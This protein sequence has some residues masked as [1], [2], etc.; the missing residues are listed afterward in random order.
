MIEL[1]NQTVEIL[2]YLIVETFKTIN[3]I[4]YLKPLVSVSSSDVCITQYEK[5]NRLYQYM[6]KTNQLTDE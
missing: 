2:N 6:F 4:F 3:Y 5:L 1:L